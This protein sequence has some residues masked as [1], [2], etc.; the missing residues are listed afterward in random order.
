[1]KKCL[2]LE[3]GRLSASSLSSPTKHVIMKTAQTTFNREA[4]TTFNRE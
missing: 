3:L 4:H 1:M 2:M